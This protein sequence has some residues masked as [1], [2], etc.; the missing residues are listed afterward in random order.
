MEKTV[1]VVVT[2]NRLSMLKQCIEHLRRQT[3]PCDILLI[4]NASTDGTSE[5]A[6]AQADVYYHNT[7]SNLGGAGGFNIGM[8]I[9]VEQGYDAVWVMDDDCFPK[10][11]ALE[12]LLAADSVAGEYGWL[13]SV[14][15]WTDGTECRMNR[16]K[17][18]KDF[19]SKMDLL[20]A[21][22]ILA[23]QATFV[24]LFIRSSTIREAGLPIKEFFIWGDDI[25]FT[26]RISVRMKR[27][28]YLA[29][30]SV[31]VHAMNKNS[32]S[33]IATDV[34]ERIERYSYAYRNEAYIYRK[35]GIRSMC[36]YIAKC[37]LNTCRILKNAPDHRWKRL[38][39]LIGSSIKGLFFNPKIEMDY[40]HGQ[41]SF[42]KHMG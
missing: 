8:R 15:L 12:G 35:E 37:G 34:S 24:S 21:G 18:R 40:T 25:E 20:P 5:W 7:G 3:K 39:I 6:N 4:D 9:A 42:N 23:E 38:L 11:D 13:S 2:Y 1:A 30:K 16:P 41:F 28:S 17:L 27:P 32:G 14:V 10:E 22:L 31:V 26:R 33:S 29:T 36:F 19:Y